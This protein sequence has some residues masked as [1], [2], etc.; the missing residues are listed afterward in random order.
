VIAAFSVDHASR[1]TGLSKTRLTRWDREGFFSPEC[2]DP[3]DAGNPYGRVYSF[4]DLVGLRTLA[5]LTDKHRIS[6]GELRK[7]YPVLAKKLKRPWSDTQLSV[8]NGK[9]VWDLDT[10]PRDRHGQIA[11]SHIELPTVASEI[12]EKAA[13]LRERDKNQIGATEQHKFVAHNARVVAGT[14]I[15][16]TAVESF[17]RAGYDDAAIVDEYP[18]LKPFDVSTIRRRMDLAA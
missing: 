16:V 9:V 3:D 4:T 18:T 13:A 15:P 8:L 2:A 14:R 7:T 17:I 10:L 1:L 5:I 11:G 6:R 12:A